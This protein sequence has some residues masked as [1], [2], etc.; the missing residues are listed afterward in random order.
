[1]EK[2]EELDKLDS[3][4]LKLLKSNKDL[5]KESLTAFNANPEHL[6]PSPCLRE[7][8]EKYFPQERKAYYWELAVKWESEDTPWAWFDEH[9]DELDVLRMYYSIVSSAF[10]R[11][12]CKGR[13]KAFLGQYDV[14]ADETS[15]EKMDEYLKCSIFS[16]KEIEYILKHRDAFLRQYDSD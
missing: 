10:Q 3:Y 4:L 11:G 15:G 16:R 6:C 9:F 8:I 2:R 5:A 7:I 13:I 14:V 1:M 12:Y